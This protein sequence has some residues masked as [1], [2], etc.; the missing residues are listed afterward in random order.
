MK[1]QL[2]AL[3]LLLLA[4]ALGWTPLSAQSQQK[5]DR[6]LISQ[7]EV[8]ASSAQ[9]AYDLVRNLRPQWLRLR[10]DHT[11]RTRTVT[12]PVGGEASVL[13]TGEIIV[14][15]DGVRYGKHED[16]RGLPLGDIGT[17]RFLD[18]SS[19]TQRFGTGHS[20]GAILVTSRSTQ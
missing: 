20:H 15:L 11:I 5:R 18:A 12:T 8:S 7:E 1:R 19:A 16:L 6:Y 17:L 9:N 10:G 4:L 14:Y 13:E 2:L 3:P